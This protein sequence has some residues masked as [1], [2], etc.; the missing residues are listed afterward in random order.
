M[1]EATNARDQWKH[2]KL[3][4][5]WTKYGGPQMIIKNGEVIT[6]PQRMANEINTDYI[7]RAAK[8]ARNTPPPLKKTP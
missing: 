1:E 8:A 3:I 2:A 6:S 5:G 4:T 7:V